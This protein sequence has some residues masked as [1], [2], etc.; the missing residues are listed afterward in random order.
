ML[1]S[2]NGYYNGSTIAID[3]ADKKAFSF[4]DKVIVTKVNKQNS[5]LDNRASRRKELLKSKSFVIKTDRTVEEINKEIKS[6][7]SERF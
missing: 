3:E 6:G 2:V 4:G 5:Y 1:V 7:R